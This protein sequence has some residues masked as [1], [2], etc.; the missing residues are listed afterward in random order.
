MI[1]LIGITIERN[2]ASSSRNDSPSTKANTIGVFCFIVRVEVGRRRRRRRSRRRTR[3]DA[4]ERGRDAC[5]RSCSSDAMASSL[6]PQPARWT[7]TL[8]TVPFGLISTSAGSAGGRSRL[9]TS[10]A[11]TSLAF[12]TTVAKSASAG[13]AF[14]IFR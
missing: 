8:A 5:S 1:A 3:L 14:W 9:C 4:V 7:L 2:V 13:N 10:A 6:T 12:T 11:L